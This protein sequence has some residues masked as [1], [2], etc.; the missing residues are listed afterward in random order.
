MGKGQGLPEMNEAAGWAAERLDTERRRFWHSAKPLNAQCPA[1]KIKP[2]VQAT[3]EQVMT[4]KTAYDKEELEILHALEVGT[5]KPV[6][7]AEK[8]KQMHRAVAKA[9]LETPPVDQSQNPNRQ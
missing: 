5:L 9:T 1:S 3:Q 7:D 8:R 6:G 4:R 2:G